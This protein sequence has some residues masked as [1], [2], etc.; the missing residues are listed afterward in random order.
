MNMSEDSNLVIQ[1]K[2]L[3]TFLLHD[4]GTRLD[5]SRHVVEQAQLATEMLDEPWK[6]A[7]LP[8]AWLHD[9]GYSKD[10][11][12]TK[13]HPLDGARYLRNEGW[14]MEI[15]RLVA[16]HTNAEAEAEMRD[17]DYVLAI[18]F[19]VPPK[20]ARELLAWADLTSSPTGERCSPQER[21]DEI[22][23]RY[24]SE[25]VV[26]RAIIQAHDQLLNTALDFQDRLSEIY[27]INGV[28]AP[29]SN[30]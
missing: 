21:L 4:T 13:F 17:L 30:P 3:A 22:L 28:S 8:A 29:L 12:I 9:I 14:S 20:E 27:P 25:T 26:H 15:C 7:L 19:E 6:S 18:E 24:G 5:H 11:G 2:E 1:A 23:E 16:W 10:I